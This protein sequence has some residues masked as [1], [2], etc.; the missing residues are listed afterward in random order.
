MATKIKEFWGVG[1]AT[2]ISKSGL[3]AWEEGMASMEPDAPVVLYR[4]DTGELDWTHKQIWDHGEPMREGRTLL[5]ET[6]MAEAVRL[7]WLAY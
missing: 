5:L 2:R 1:E 6:T 4:R 3:R 7:K